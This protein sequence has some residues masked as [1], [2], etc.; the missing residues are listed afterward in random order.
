MHRTEG[1]K[2]S[3]PDVLELRVGGLQLTATARGQGPTALCLHGFPDT[4]ATFDGL[5]QALV[6]AGYRV[7][8][9]WQRGYTPAGRCPDGDYRVSTAANDALAWLDLL[10]VDQALVIGHDWGA[11]TGYALA[12]SQPQRVRALVTL[13]APPMRRWILAWYYPSVW[14]IVPWQLRDSWYFFYLAMPGAAARILRDNLAFIQRV[15]AVSSPGWSPGP[16]RDVAIAALS[17]P[18]V[19]EASL[20]WYRRFYDIFLPGSASREWLTAPIEAPTLAIAGA[21]DGVVDLRT[22]RR[23]ARADQFPAGLDLHAIEG[24]GHFPHLEKPEQVEALIVE[25]LARH[26]P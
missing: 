2:P 11:I 23:L 4:P 15:C 22:F 20:G 1:M 6:H 19:L 12:A 3:M 14:P 9:P 10:E 13:V 17:E 8:C 25:W 7:V 21:I 26:R 18:G 24:A 16:S 5:G